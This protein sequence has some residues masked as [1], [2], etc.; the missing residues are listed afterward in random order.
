MM[1]L[2]TGREPDAV[3]AYKNDASEIWSPSVDQ[4]RH[5]YAESKGDLVRTLTF[6]C[7]KVYELGN[8]RE[9]EQLDAALREGRWYIFDRIR[10]HLYAKFP[11][12]TK[13]WIREA[14]LSYRAYAEEQYGFEFQRMTRVA[15]E[16]FGAAILS[17]DEL[18]NIFEVIVNAPDKEDYKQ[19]MAD[20][21]TEEGYRHRQE[22]FQHRH[23]RPFAS[24]LF[25][26]YKDRYT[27]LLS[28][29]PALTDEDFVRFGVGETKT[30][31]SR[32]PK[33]IAELALLTDDELIAFLNDW[34]DAHQDADE[35]WVDIDFT[36]LATAFQQLI[37]ANPNRF[38][39][40]GERWH[41]LQRPIYLRYALD[42]ATKRIG[43][44]Q[45]EL[46][47]WLDIADWVMTRSEPP[48][49][50]D[51]KNSETSRTHPSWNSARTQVVDL[52]AACVK[53]EVNVDLEWR[54]RFIALL[55]AACVSPDYYL[56]SNKPIITPRDFLTDAINTM[57]GRA[58]ETLL[59][60][61]FWVKRH[62]QSAD[63]ADLFDVLQS[64]ARWFAPA[65][66]AR[67]CAVRRQLPSTIRA[68]LVLGSGKC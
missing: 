28:N 11:E 49:T 1:R 56:D 31:A 67:V 17:Q 16:Q 62:E 47:Q 4:Q 25:G 14:I 24:V 53:K 27:A 66:A 40:W 19:F 63:L 20:Q 54:P 38:L 22:Y 30:G 34:D 51:E 8:D 46:H 21:F 36:G 43:E 55:K 6:A 45:P 44:H 35:W 52:L 10:Y 29:R 7:E 59:R 39:G 13:A 12:R 58:I 41:A 15:L 68:Q 42:A 50:G 9:A 57:R 18:M 61:G 33:S 32:S 60:Y 3:D 37:L 23:L 64:A 65:C 48:P 2:D 5:P 26:K